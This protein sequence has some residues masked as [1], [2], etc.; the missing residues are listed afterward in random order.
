MENTNISQKDL[1]EEQSETSDKSDGKMEQ[2]EMIKQTS[3]IKRKKKRKLKFKLEPA[4]LLSDFF[5][6][7]I[8]K[9]VLVC[10]KASDI[11]NI[12]IHLSA[13]ETAE[14]TG[15]Q[16]EKFWIQQKKRYFIFQ[17]VI[18]H[19]CLRLYI[20]HSEVHIYRWEF[21]KFFGRHLVG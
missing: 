8:I 7:W 21:G 1:L 5:L 10:R 12:H 6:A 2:I 18:L 19:P 11:R 17:L 15:N 20:T 14:K 13:S 9:L 3:T 16:L 4:N